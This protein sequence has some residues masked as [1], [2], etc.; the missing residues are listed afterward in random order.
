MIQTKQLSDAGI[1]AFASWLGSPSGTTPPAGLLDG[2]EETL[3]LD[4][5]SVDAG[6]TFASRFEF[7]IYLNECFADGRFS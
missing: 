7:G 6:R 1:E 3:P 2:D 5:F 4:G